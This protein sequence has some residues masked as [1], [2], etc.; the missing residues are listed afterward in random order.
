MKIKFSS[1]TFQ[2]I[3]DTHSSESQWTQVQALGM[4]QVRCLITRFSC[5]I[6]ELHLQ[7][8]NGLFFIDNV[9]HQLLNDEKRK[10]FI[11]VNSLVLTELFQFYREPIILSTAYH[12]SYST[13]ICG[14]NQDKQRGY[15]NL[16][17]Q[18]K[19]SGPRLLIWSCFQ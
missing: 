14:M 9:P 13:N 19:E 1:Y 8:S 15:S 12:K 4:P 5:V 17:K 2:Y 18:E 10:T 6:T 11:F 7:S 3:L 16:P